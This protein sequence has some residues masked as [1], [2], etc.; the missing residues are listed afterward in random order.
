MLTKQLLFG[1]DIPTDVLISFMP[2][3]IRRI[4]FTTRRT[5]SCRLP[6]VRPW[7]DRFASEYADECIYLLDLFRQKYPGRYDTADE[8]VFTCMEDASKY[9]I[10]HVAEVQK[11]REEAQQNKPLD[12]G[13]EALHLSTSPVKQANT[14]I[15]RSKTPTPE[16]VATMRANREKYEIKVEGY[17]RRGHT[18]R[19]A[20]RYVPCS[21]GNTN[22]GTDSDVEMELSSQPGDVTTAP[23]TKPSSG[24]EYPSPDPSS[25]LDRGNN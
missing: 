16:E 22:V 15:F 11:A 25:E 23:S 2:C 8:D 1:V 7:P 20:E 21:R 12:A 18:Y 13:L 3:S 9:V 17:L 19:P 6:R 24:S 5:C 10:D 4:F 14:R